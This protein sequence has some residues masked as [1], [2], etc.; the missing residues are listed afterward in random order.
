VQREAQ[1]LLNQAGFPN[2]VQRIVLAVSG[3]GSGQSM[4]GTLHFTYVLHGDQYEE[5]NSIAVST[6]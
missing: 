2:S 5:D 4:S 1:S 6:P 3:P